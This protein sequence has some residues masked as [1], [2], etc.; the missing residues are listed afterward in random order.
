MHDTPEPLILPSRRDAL[1]RCLAA[2]DSACAPVL[3]S[4]DPGMGKTWLIDRIVERDESRQWLRLDLSPSLTPPRFLSL[5]AHRLGLAPR[6]I[7]A[8]LPEF[9]QAERDSGRLWALAL[10]EA[11]LAPDATLEE[12]RVLANRI[13]HADGLDALLLAAQPGLNARL[14]MRH[15]RGLDTRIGA[16]IALGPVPFEEAIQ[17]VGPAASESPDRV[18]RWLRNALGCP[19]ALLQLR[20]RANLARDLVLQAAAPPPEIPASTLAPPAPVALIPSEPPWQLDD[21][22]IE[23]GWSDDEAPEP[24][25]ELDSTPTLSP[26]S[27]SSHA[28]AAAIRDADRVQ[29]DESI[30]DDSP[31][32][33]EDHYASLQAW[34]EWSSNQGR[35]PA[36]EHPGASS[37]TPADADAAAACPRVRAEAQHGFAPYSSLFSRPL[38]S[39]EAP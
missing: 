36:T 24:A 37:T 32:T 25:D 17:L 3:L 13:G 10:D 19:G 39:P 12:V 18:R 34:N 22:T 23:V 8:E 5:L 11:H 1:D 21:A 7:A 14:R 30:D 16:R 15:L 4:A 2:L 27:D 28:L 33:I 6:A 26:T 29:Q 35:V 9:L 20:D 31:R 38:A